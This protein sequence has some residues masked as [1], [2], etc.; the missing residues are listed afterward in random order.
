M[1]SFRFLFLFLLLFLIPY[2]VYK[3]YIQHVRFRPPSAYEYTANK[4]IDVFYHDPEVVKQYYATCLQ[5]GNIARNAWYEK[6]TDV[7]MMDENDPKHQPFIRQYQQTQAAAKFLEEKLLLSKKLKTLGLNNDDIQA[8]ETQYTN[9]A[10]L[11]VH[12]G[13]QMAKHW[14]NNVL[15]MGDNNTDVYVLQKMLKDLGYE[16]PID[17]YYESITKGAVDKFQRDYKIYPT[18]IINDLTA[19]M[20]VYQKWKK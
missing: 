13:K 18:G 9:E 5:V 2:F 11:P 19:G 1:K 10:E 15:Q 14:K 16:L 6:Q 12:I 20:I 8:I 3:T 7:Q 17:G 4:E